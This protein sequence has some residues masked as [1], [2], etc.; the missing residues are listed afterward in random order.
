VIYLRNALLIGVRQV[1]VALG[2]WL[3]ARG[4]QMREEESAAL[5]NFI[6]GVLMALAS[7]VWANWAKRRDQKNPDPAPKAT[8]PPNILPLLLLCVMIVGCTVEDAGKVQ[9][10]A[11]GV[12]EATT[13]PAVQ[14]LVETV[15]AARPIVGI[16]ELAA[17]AVMLLAGIFVAR[18]STHDSR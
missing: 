5:A 6:V 2:V 14:L 13:Q 9:E 1:L 15:P 3:A 16:V 12:K 8:F 11:K 10:I 7:F 4:Y 18:R 17:G